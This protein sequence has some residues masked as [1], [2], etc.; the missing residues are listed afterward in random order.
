MDRESTVELARYRAISNYMPIV[1]D[2]I[3]VH[4][5]FIQRVKWFGII[6]GVSDDKISVV[7]SGLPKLLLTMTEKEMIKS[8][9]ELSLDSIRKSTGAYTILQQSKEKAMVWY[10]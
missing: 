3:M 10:V 8:T 4:G 5:M 6:N 2:F 1:G 7:K 9:V